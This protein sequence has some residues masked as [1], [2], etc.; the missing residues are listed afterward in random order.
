MKDNWIKCDQCGRSM[1]GH[2]MVTINRCNVCPKCSGAGADSSPHNR[3]EDMRDLEQRTAGQRR[4]NSLLHR[5]R[6]A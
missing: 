3:M 2:E 4:K 1:P 5:Q 6:Y